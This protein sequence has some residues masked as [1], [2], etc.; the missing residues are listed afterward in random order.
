MMASLR[1][2][3]H[4]RRL[5]PIGRLVGITLAVAGLTA[6]CGGPAADAPATVTISETT[7][8]G[9]VKRWPM[10]LA[11]GAVMPPARVVI[12][13]L[14]TAPTSAYAHILRETF[15]NPA[16]GI[17]SIYNGLTIPAVWLTDG[18]TTLNPHMY[19]VI[20]NNGD[21][22]ASAIL[23]SP[24]HLRAE[25]AALMQSHYTLQAQSPYTVVVQSVPT[26]LAQQF[27]REVSAAAEN[28]SDIGSTPSYL[29]LWVGP[30]RAS[31]GS[32]SQPSNPTAPQTG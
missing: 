26:A 12:N 29:I 16:L 14:Q 18:R 7:L 22:P 32:A 3:R 24:I 13:P 20:E 9:W 25:V 27:Y 5:S 8:A 4:R 10:P 17:P 1:Q 21:L 15:Q 11:T 28:Y 31:S 2:R 6:G 19:A 23:A 30:G